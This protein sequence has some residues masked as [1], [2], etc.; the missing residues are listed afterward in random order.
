MTIIGSRQGL[1]FL[2]EN[3]I[4][5]RPSHSGRDHQ[6]AGPPTYAARWV[7]CRARIVYI[8]GLRGRATAYDVTHPQL[9]EVCRGS[10]I[11]VDAAVTVSSSGG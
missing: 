6:N 8:S 2:I 5:H 4:I 10:R 11:I 3:L 9:I 7:V 1:I